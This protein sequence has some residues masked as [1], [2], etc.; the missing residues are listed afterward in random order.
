MKKPVFF[1]KT[2]FFISFG[3]LFGVGAEIR[4]MWIENV[5]METKSSMKISFA[6]A[7]FWPS[8]ARLS[9]AKSS[10]RC[11]RPRRSVCCLSTTDWQWWPS[12]QWIWA[13]IPSLSPL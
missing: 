12:R 10:G 4:I 5:P 7:F 11:Y 2:G 1:A 9:S 3:R 8:W 13:E 6:L